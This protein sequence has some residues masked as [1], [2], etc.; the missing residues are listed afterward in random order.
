MILLKTPVALTSYL[1]TTRA[2]A[3]TKFMDLN[4]I[5]RFQSLVALI[6]RQKAAMILSLKS[7]QRQSHL[8]AQLACLRSTLMP[9]LIKILGR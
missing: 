2:T 4:Q 5:L 3:M 9:Q 8:W 7:A 6:R 1:N